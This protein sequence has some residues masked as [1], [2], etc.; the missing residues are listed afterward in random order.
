MY[1]RLMDMNFWRDTMKKLLSLVLMLTLTGGAA[2]QDGP[3]PMTLATALENLPDHGSFTVEVSS[4]LLPQAQLQE[5]VGQIGRDAMDSHFYGAIYAYVPAKSGMMEIKVRRGLHSR[6]AAMAGARADCEEARSP[7]DSE[8]TLFG[9]ILPEGWTE[10]MPQLHHEAVKALA[11]NADQLPEGVVVA[12][13]LSTSV[14]EIW[15]GENARGAL[16]ACNEANLAA[17]H[18]PDCQIIIDDDA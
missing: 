14:F 10:V 15:A 1:R 3:A 11:D 5:I 12:R 16:E 8:C 4:N 2:A 18:E 13:S 17:G 9:E 7:G 6:G